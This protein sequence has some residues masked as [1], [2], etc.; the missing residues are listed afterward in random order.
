M[1]SACNDGRQ[2]CIY[3][4]PNCVNVSKDVLAIVPP[5][6]SQPSLKTA[7]QLSKY[8]ETIKENEETIKKL[9][10]TEQHLLQ[11]VETQNEEMTELKKKL[12]DDPAFHTVEYVE[13]K[14]EKKLESFRKEILSTIKEECTKSYAA[15]AST[16]RDVVTP[17]DDIKTAVKEVHL[18]EAAEEKE[19]V[20]R[21]KNIIIHGVEEQTNDA[22]KKDEEWVKTLI[23]SLRV[24]VNVMRISRIGQPSDGKKRPLIVSLKSEEEKESVFGNL[25]TLKGNDTYNGVSICEDLTL[26][27]RKKYKELANEAKTKNLTETDGVWRVRGFAKNGFRLKKMNTTNKQ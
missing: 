20:R 7:A 16:K 4:C 18:E 22:S 3:K 24:K 5:P 21:S 17:S 13:N 9:K 23:T 8:K 27:Q 12:A 6:G 2:K 26:E 19:K 14:L 25:P 10:T 11:I 1:I 15:A